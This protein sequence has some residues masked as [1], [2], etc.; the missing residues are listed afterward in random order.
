ME[1]TNIISIQS[2][3]QSINKRTLKPVLCFNIEISIE[4]IMF[5][6]EGEVANTIGHTIVDRIQEIVKF[7]KI[8]A[9]FDDVKDKD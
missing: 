6:M 1:A 3:K 2:V 8:A 7:R 5:E 4:D 9:S